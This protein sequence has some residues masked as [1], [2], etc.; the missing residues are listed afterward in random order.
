MFESTVFK[1]IFPCHCIHKCYYL[2]FRTLFSSDLQYI[3]VYTY[4]EY[5]KQM[6]YLNQSYFRN[7]K[8]THQSFSSI[9]IL[10]T[11][12]GHMWSF[13]MFNLC[14]LKAFWYTIPNPFFLQLYPPFFMFLAVSAPYILLWN[15]HYG[16]KERHFI[17][18]I[19]Q[20]SVFLS[21][22]SQK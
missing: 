5:F 2:S 18:I 19:R 12:A 1:T 3:Y 10:Y 8:K 20:G 16:L 11:C 4:I 15:N 21:M 9:I 22:S 7:E 13:H 17:V 14:I 6:V